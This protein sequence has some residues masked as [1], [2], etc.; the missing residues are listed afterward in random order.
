MVQ[1]G[2]RVPRKF[3]DAGEYLADA[4]ALDAAGVDALWLEGEGHDPWLL[5]A[6][7]AAV[8]GRIRLVVPV[9]AEDASAP[10][11]VERRLIT[12]GRLSRGRVV[13]GVAVNPYAEPV[14]SLVALARRCD[15]PVLLPVSGLAQART[16]ALLSDG[17]VG[18]DDSP[19]QL[20]EAL[21]VIRPL[22]ERT[23]RKD[24]LELWIRTA[25][26]TE[27]AH[28]RST[29]AVWEAAGATGLILPSDPRLLD[30][31]RNGDEEDDRSDLTLAQG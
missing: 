25:M 3:E 24:P 21:T 10:A 9:A 12:L 4:R 11:A 2:V 22:R 14:D 5:L 29:R 16:A 6:S 8:T 17:L 31:L 28:W 27:P 7:I 20:R 19:D 13:F 26:P 1:I 18:L 30:L 15:C 23:G